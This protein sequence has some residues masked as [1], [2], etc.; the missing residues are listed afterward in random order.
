MPTQSHYCIPQMKLTPLQDAY[1]VRLMEA[2]SFDIEKALDDEG[3][4]V[5]YL[6]D[7]CGDREGEPWYTFE[8][9]I[10]DTEDVVDRYYAEEVA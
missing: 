8:D 4:H 7:P 10:L 5:Y 2:T 9:L 3:A 1:R 6:V